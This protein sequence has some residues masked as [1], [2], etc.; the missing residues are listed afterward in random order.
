MGLA[1]WLGFNT[2]RVLPDPAQTSFS[3]VSTFLQDL[4]LEQTPEELWASQP[5]LRTVVDFLSRNVA[6]LGVYAYERKSEGGAERLTNHTL[7]R[8]LRKPN[9]EQTNYEFFRSL[10]GD[11]ALYDEAFAVHLKEPREDNL[12]DSV[13]LLRPNWVVGT[14]G[15]TAY[16]VKFYLVQFPESPETFEVPAEK[17]LHFHGWNPSDPRTGLTPLKAL[18]HTLGE[19]LAA[20]TFRKQLWQRG[21]RVGS[22]LSR[23]AGAPKWDSKV[24]SAF[25]TAFR[26]AW[27][28][29]NATS[30]GGVP[31]LEDGMTLQRVGFSAKEEQF[32][33]GTKLSLQTV[34]SVYHVNPTMVGLLDNANYSNVREFRRSL[35]GETLGPRLV[36]LEQRLNEFLLPL[37]GFDNAK[38][39][40]E[41]DVASRLRGSVDE[42][43]K[44][45]QS[46][47]GGP[48]LTVNE[49]RAQ[50]NLPALE[51][52]DE[53]IR[54]KNLY[55]NGEQGAEVEE[56]TDSASTDEDEENNQ[57]GGPAADNEE[58]NQ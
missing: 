29:Q 48:W 32:V 55:Q 15:A 19:Q 5:H 22:Y 31:L 14:K 30:G 7:A 38:Y 21:G 18:Q 23:P 39:Y 3:T 1:S 43:A 41:F 24:R 58:E 20:A 57:T 16:D 8:L 17:V 2:N 4:A 47:V 35:Y 12:D 53:L 40:L 11:L 27:T 54:P 50:N 44:V 9:P 36:E 34:A 51:G 45:L 49:A 13:R 56:E 37:L 33:E 28:G 26:N 42:Q 46:A 52:G 25:L 10:V 6:Q